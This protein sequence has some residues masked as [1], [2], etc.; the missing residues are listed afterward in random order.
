MEAQVSNARWDGI[1]IGFAVTV[2]L[3]A[4]IA[5]TYACTREAMQKEAIANG[6]GRWVLVGN[7]AEFAW[8]GGQ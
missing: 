7:K 8:G 3:G 2:V 4:A 1:M 6:A 5:I